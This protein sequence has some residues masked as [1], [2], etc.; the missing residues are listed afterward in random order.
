[1]DSRA[2]VLK[3]IKAKAYREGR[4][5]LASGATSNWY[6]DLSQI[7]LDGKHFETLQLCLKQFLRQQR[8][9]FTAAGGLTMGADPLAMILAAATSSKAFS[10]R[11]AAKDH[12]AEAGRIVGPLT[13]NDTILVVD[14]IATT[15]NS[16]LEPI[17]LLLEE[18]MKILGA[19][20][21][22]DRSGGQA[23][24]KLEAVHIPFYAVFEAAEIRN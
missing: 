5:K 3:L 23:A 12:G 1:M 19:L 20:V 18:G 7:Q 10:I 17:Q 16:L 9:K 24:A 2:E 4:F 8:L 11:A 22:V 6:L 14:D 15:G 21:L 13:R